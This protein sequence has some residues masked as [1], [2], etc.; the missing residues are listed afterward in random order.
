MR[1]LMFEVPSDDTIDEIIIDKACIT[2]NAPPEI[3]RS[4]KQI[5]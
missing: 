3:K 2:E 4:H 1:D 5:A